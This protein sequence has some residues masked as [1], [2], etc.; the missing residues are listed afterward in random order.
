MEKF[1]GECNAAKSES[2]PLMGK[3]RILEKAPVGSNKQ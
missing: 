1:N 2:V 3:A